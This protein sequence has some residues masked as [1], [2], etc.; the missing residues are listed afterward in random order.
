MP[1]ISKISHIYHVLQYFGRQSDLGILAILTDIPAD[2]H[3]LFLQTDILQLDPGQFSWAYQCVIMHLARQQEGRVL[4]GQILLKE[5]HIFL[6]QWFPFL[7]ILRE[8]LYFLH[9][10]G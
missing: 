7:V 3:S 5:F 8:L 10:G 2:K 9:A 1:W 4:V 6:L